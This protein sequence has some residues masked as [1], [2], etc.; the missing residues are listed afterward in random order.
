MNFHFK[1]TRQQLNAMSGDSRKQQGFCKLKDPG[2]NLQWRLH[3]RSQCT[4]SPDL[5][6]IQVQEMRK[7]KENNACEREREERKREIEGLEFE[8]LCSDHLDDF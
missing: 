8:S 3:R 4:N 1:R 7:D 5:K 6:N 2:F